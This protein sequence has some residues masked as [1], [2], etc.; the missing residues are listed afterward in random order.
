MIY[1]GGIFSVFQP[2][3]GTIAW[4]VSC[5]SF[6]FLTL[7]FGSPHLS[8]RH[9]IA[10]KAETPLRVA[11]SLARRHVTVVG[12]YHLWIQYAKWHM[13]TQHSAANSEDADSLLS[14][15]CI[16]ELDG[17]ILSDVVVNEPAR[18]CTLSFDLGATLH[19][20][21]DPDYKEDQWG[22]YALDGHIVALEHDGSLVSEA[23]KAPVSQDASDPDSIVPSNINTTFLK[24]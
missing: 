3:I 15:E 5:A 22:L 16:R 8:I 21:R 9:P 18:S 17:Q 20:S 12:D 23:P 2:L 4:S 13:T 24:M 6:P 7:E 19:L 11:R 1:E 14:I 10:A